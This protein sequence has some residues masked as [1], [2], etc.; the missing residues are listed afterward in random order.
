MKNILL[1]K[2]NGIYGAIRAYIDEFEKAFRS[3][4]YNTIVLDFMVANFK[5]RYERIMENY[6]IYAVVDCQGM[7]LDL[8]PDISEREDILHV[9]YFCDHPLYHTKRLSGAKNNSLILNLDN[10]HTEYIKRFYP[11]FLNAAFVPLGGSRAKVIRPYKERRIDVLFT[12][13]YWAP[14]KP[15]QEI[16]G[17]GFVQEVRN[18]V[19]ERM[20]THPK[21]SIEDILERVLQQYGLAIEAEEFTEILSEFKNIETYV[22]RYYRDCIMRTLLKAGIHVCVYGS[23][24]EKLE[25]EGRENLTVLPGGIEVAKRALGN[26][27]IALNI[28]PGF[29]AGFQER[30]ADAMLGGAV[31]VTDT[32]SYI[33][34]EFR[35]GKEIVLYRLDRIDELPQKIKE[36]LKDEERAAGIAAAGRNLAA[37]KHTWKNRVQK[38]AELIENA[39]A[40]EYCPSGQEG[41]A[42]EASVE[43]GDMHCRIQEIGVRLS[44]LADILNELDDYGYIRKDDVTELLDKLDTYNRILKRTCGYEF[45]AQANLELFSGQI[46]AQMMRS[47]NFK[48]TVLMVLLMVSSILNGMKEK[49]R[50]AQL[51]CMMVHGTIEEE[52]AL[53]NEMLAKFLLVKYQD[54]REECVQQWMESIRRTKLAQC[55]PIQLLDKYKDLPIEML[56]DEQQ[57][58]LC[59]MHHGRRMYYPREYSMEKVYTEYRFCCIEQDMQSPHRYLDER[60]FVEPGSVVIDA[61]TAE[62]IFAL[63]IIDLV[64]KIYL[65]ECDPK[66]LEALQATFGPYREKVVFVPKMLGNRTDAEWTTIDEI[67]GG[68]RID[69]IKMDVE[70]CEADALLGAEETFRR[71][72]T[73]KCVIATYHARGMEDRVKEHLRNR[74]FSISNVPGY[75]LYKNYEVPLWENELRHALVRAERNG[76]KS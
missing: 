17:T 32:S 35:D 31:S 65:V 1:I 38:M 66:W 42:L 76:E 58:M 8:L 25:C 22:R 61:G 27:K 51:E 59:V 73:M 43:V 50:A 29:K 44:A 45:L 7:L 67:A 23:G 56:Y 63:D 71:N 20:L 46:K 11:R 57:D 72:K 39:H 28:M 47:E 69:F 40:E 15:I 14:E 74:N 60:F 4:G 55:Y 18:K 68:Q 75:I 3:L 24:W 53:Y 9:H 41:S 36:L 21:E 37:E 16:E 13:S 34:E 52:E 62:G 33:E 49:L 70:G 64:S 30:I 6:D 48:E 10:K 12:G 26:T 54:N 19:L 2:G 5:K